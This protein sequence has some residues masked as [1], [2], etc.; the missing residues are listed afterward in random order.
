MYTRKDIKTIF[1]N[2]QKKKKSIGQFNF[3]DIAQIKGIIKAVNKQ[4][5]IPLI[6]GTSEGESKYFGLNLSFSIYEAI[7]KEIKNP[8]FLNLDHGKSFD[9]IKKAIDAGYK[10]VHFDGS[11]FSLKENISL[12]KK[13]VDFAHKKDVFVEG[14]IGYLR[15]ESKVFKK[16]IQIKSTDKTNPQEA[17]EFVKKTGVD[18]LAIAV[19]NI[20]GIYSSSP[21]LDIERI[22]EIKNKIGE[23][24]FLVLHGGSGIPETQLKKAINA[25]IV[26]ININTEI[27]NAWRKGL[28]KSLK[29][30]KD[31]VAP[32]K[33]FEPIVVDEVAKII[34]KKI[35]IFNS[36]N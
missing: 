24:V 32:Y 10:M 13:I 14:E 17:L 21:K 3:S 15:G 20:H 26:K 34:K 8:V 9:Y 12:T 36:Y 18:S 11:Q 25:G 4:K 35:E 19:G 23:N 29:L 5:Q 2:L 7:Q 30:Q 1:F 16:N 27:R 33:I 28:E 22:K 6:L 31:E